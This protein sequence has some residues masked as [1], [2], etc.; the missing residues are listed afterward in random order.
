MSIGL[1]ASYNRKTKFDVFCYLSGFDRHKFLNKGYN[2][3]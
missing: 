1:D 2:F 3:N